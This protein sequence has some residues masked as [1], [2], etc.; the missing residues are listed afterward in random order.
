MGSEEGE[1]AG[2]MRRLELMKHQP[3]E[4]FGKDANGQEEIGLTP[5]PA[6]PVQA[7]ATARHNHVHMRV[8][9]HR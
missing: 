9:H 4:Q 1:L 2:H 7:D 3:P 6:R 5:D 8:M